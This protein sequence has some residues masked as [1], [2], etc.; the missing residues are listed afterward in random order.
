MV[1]FLHVRRWEKETF[2][3][4]ELK[5]ANTHIS[6]TSLDHFVKKYILGI[7]EHFNTENYTWRLVIIQNLYEV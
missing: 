3:S 6:V 1:E 4:F 5:C 2:M 7:L